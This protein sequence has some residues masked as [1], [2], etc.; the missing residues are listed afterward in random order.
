MVDSGVARLIHTDVAR[1]GM[2]AGPGLAGLS[3]LTT[4][5]VPVM[6]AGGV[7]SY[8]DLKQIREGGAEAAIVGRALLDGTITLP[9]AIAAAGGVASAPAEA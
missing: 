8:Q 7:S 6:V 4:L 3:E 1:D 9:A 2:L 5:G